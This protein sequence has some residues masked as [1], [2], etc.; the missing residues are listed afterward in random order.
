[1]ANLTTTPSKAKTK[2][3]GDPNAAYESMRPLWERARAV[4]NGQTHARAYDDVIDTAN[5]SNLL[6]PFSPTMSPQQYN[7][8]RAEG[9]LP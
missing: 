9:E 5:Y 1:M 2:S 8:Y 7:F 6:L 3:L 4:L